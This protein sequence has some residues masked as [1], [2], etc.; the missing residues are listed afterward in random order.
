VI[1]LSDALSGGR[2]RPA[3]DRPAQRKGILRKSILPG[4]RERML[5]HPYTGFWDSMSIKFRA[6]H[7]IR[8]ALCSDIRSALLWARDTLQP[9]RT[10]ALDS[11]L[12]LAHLL[13]RNRVWV[14][15]HDDDVLSQLQS[16]AFRRLVQLR[17]E[18]VPVGHL[19]GF[20][21]WYGMRLKVSSDVLIPRPETELLLEA[22]LGLVATRDV[23]LAVDV[24]TG[25]GALAIGLAVHAAGLQ[26]VATDSSSPAIEL[27]KANAARCRVD[28]RI[29][30]LNCDLLEGL[31]TSP[32]M[33]VANLPYL[34][35]AMMA[36]LP[37]DVRH[38]PPE[39]LR[40]GPSG[41][42]L[43]G[44][45]FEQMRLREMFVPCLIEI[46]PRQS[47]AL[48]DLVG[49]YFP[50]ARVDISIDYSGTER[51]ASIEPEP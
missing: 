30:I 45:L 21:E 22:A 24:G 9:S 31:D 51:L 8:G 3:Y 44:R 41:L 13:N 35:S 25:S 49:G 11:E 7:T 18:G 42:E 32:D 37:R 33:I 20:V 6:Q 14:L 4:M 29:T 10:A 46:D 12:L 39:A 5:V 47:L 2:G 50:R 23:R 17:A 19:R 26:V 1:A 38:E 48:K 15:A 16:R 43:Y 40:G 28:D 27:A 36:E 34:S